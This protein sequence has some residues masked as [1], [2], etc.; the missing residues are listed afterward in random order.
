MAVQSRHYLGIRLAFM[1][2]FGIASLCAVT[3]LAQGASIGNTPLTDVPI[4]APK[5][6]GPCASN[7]PVVSIERRLA[8]RVGAKFVGC[9]R[10]KDMTALHG[11]GAK[12]PFPVEYAIASSISGG[13]F[14]PADIDL[15]LSKVRK[16]WKDFQPLS[17]EHREYIAQLNAFIQEG[18][19][20]AG[21]PSIT[22]I[23]PTLIAIERLDRLAYVVIS[24]RHYV[25]GDGMVTSTKADGSA[26]VLQGT[27]LVQL[28]ILRE[29][30]DP[31]DVGTVRTQIVAWAHEVM[32]SSGN[33]PR[34]H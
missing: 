9:F 1:A 27:R 3:A 30:R 10:S 24:V 21:E 16:Q 33:A 17:S 8:P 31:S 25:S 18:H 14:S 22:S 15:L 12:H 28:Q 6:L 20:K 7:D 34:S 29:L 2:S 19:P 5:G 32:A 11:N 23:K 26:M 13:P 4:P